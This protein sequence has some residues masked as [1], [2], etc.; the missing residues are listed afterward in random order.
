MAKS[1]GYHGELE[2][3]EDLS[4]Q[5]KRYVGLYKPVAKQMMDDVEGAHRVIT[6]DL[7]EALDAEQTSS[8]NNQPSQF[9]R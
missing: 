1:S 6:D 7:C 3:W 8:Q 4:W 9:L 2:K 5:L